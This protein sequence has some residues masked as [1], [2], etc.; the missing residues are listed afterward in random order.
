MAAAIASVETKKKQDIS[1][2]YTYAL[3]LSLDLT[4]P[5]LLAWSLYTH[6]MCALFDYAAARGLVETKK[7]LDIL[8]LPTY[9]GYTAARAPVEQKKKE[10]YHTSTHTQC[11]SA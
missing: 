6:N 1:S 5:S 2:L 10:I 8:S 4:L 3:C 11:F 7:N 9:T